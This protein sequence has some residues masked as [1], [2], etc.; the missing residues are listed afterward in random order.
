MKQLKIYQKAERLTKS[1]EDNLGDKRWVE[2]LRK[3]A[4][5]LKSLQMNS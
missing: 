5:K 4:K 1:I 3:K 2:K